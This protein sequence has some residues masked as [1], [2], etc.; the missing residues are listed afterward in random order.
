MNN[1]VHSPA[2]DRLIAAHQA[3]QRIAERPDPVHM[4]ERCRTAVANRFDQIFGKWLCAACSSPGVPAAAEALRGQVVMMRGEDAAT[5]AQILVD[6]IAALVDA[7][8]SLRDLVDTQLTVTRD[9]LGALETTIGLTVARADAVLDRFGRGP[10][11]LLRTQ[12]R[13]AG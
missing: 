2:M 4:C 6:Q 5:G 12:I 13:R 11:G 8:N 10:V 3:G 7:V 1:V 9:K